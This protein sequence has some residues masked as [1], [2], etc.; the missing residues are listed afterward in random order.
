M[1]DPA[2]TGWHLD[3][4]VPLALIIAIAVQ[5]F[6]FRMWM[7]KLGTRV[8]TLEVAQSRNHGDADRL[9][10]LEVRIE[11]VQ[12]AVERIDRRIASRSDR[13]ARSP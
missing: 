8:D 9:T 11:H 4:R 12:R 3:R 2:S 6:G 1:E 7:G 5:T 13:N 10:R